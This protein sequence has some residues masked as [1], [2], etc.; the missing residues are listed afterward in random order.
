MRE[1]IREWVHENWWFIMTVG[2][3]LFWVFAIGMTMWLFP[4]NVK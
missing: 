1:K 4:L 2:S 3:C